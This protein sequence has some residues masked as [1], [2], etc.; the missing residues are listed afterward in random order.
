MPLVAIDLT[1]GTAVKLME[2]TIEIRDR[3]TR[4]YWTRVNYTTVVPP[5]TSTLI[6]PTA[7]YVGEKARPGRALLLDGIT[8]LVISIND[9]P[10]APLY[11]DNLRLER[12]TET[13]GVLFEGLWAFDVGP[14]GSPLMDGFTPL[15]ARKIYSARRGYGWKNA[16]FWRAF[17]ALQ[18]DP[19]YRD[20][21][22]VEKGGLAVDVPDGNY[23]VVVNMDSPS[24]FWGEYQIYR[25]RTLIVEGVHYEDTMDLAWFKKRYFRN[26][27]K[28]DLPSDDTFDKYQVPYFQE[29]HVTAQ[30]RD[31]QRNI[32]FEGENW[33]CCVSAIIVY[34]DAKAEQGQRFLDYVKARRAFHFN[35]SFKRVLHSPSGEA[36]QPNAADKQNGFLV[37]ARNWMED[38]YHNDRPRPGEIVERFSASAFAGE[39][40]PVVV[41]LLALQDTGAAT[42]TVGDLKNADGAVLLS[43]QKDAKPGVYRVTVRIRTERGGVCSL[44]L[45]FTVRKGTLD[46][47][48]IP[49]G[50]FSYT[51]DLP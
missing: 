3:Q 35:N 1:R 33:A 25:Q 50:P 26:W 5:G 17:D 9:K 48:D 39:Y 6:L 37:F 32:D 38:V 18:P 19:L 44:P 21:L 24:G 27:D 34:P 49:V 43:K 29:K 42:V 40:E 31:G 8:R 14:A 12:D 47:V 30:V 28:E 45:D 7:L 20:F 22:C 11:L 2:V 16:H 36:A 13:A 15:D 46:A 51:I 23:H 4:D 10:E 41:S